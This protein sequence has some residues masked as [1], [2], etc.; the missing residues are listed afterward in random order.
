MNIFFFFKGFLK[1][2]GSRSFL[3]NPQLMG[4][5]MKIYSHLSCAWFSFLFW[6]GSRL[7]FDL[8]RIIDNYGF[9][10]SQFLLVF[11]TP[12]FLL[13][14]SH[15]KNL[16]KSKEGMRSGYFWGRCWISGWMLSVILG[17]LCIKL[18]GNGGQCIHQFLVAAEQID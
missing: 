14:V 3:M 15:W 18:G 8:R 6:W 2:P 13:L 12:P 4:Q 17:L 10:L 1:K 16:N 9:F 7:D 11:P 5:K